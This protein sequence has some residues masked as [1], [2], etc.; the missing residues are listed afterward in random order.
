M[1]PPSV[2]WR[3]NND[4]RLDRRAHRLWRARKSAFESGRRIWRG[5]PGY[6][7]FPNLA[8]PGQG[9][10]VS[11]RFP[12]LGMT[13]FSGEETLSVSTIASLKISNST[14][15]QLPPPRTL[16]TEKIPRC[17]IN[18]SAAQ[19]TPIPFLSDP[20]PRRMS[21]PKLDVA[22]LSST[23]VNVTAG[24]PSEVL[25]HVLA[26]DIALVKDDWLA[27]IRRQESL[28]RVCRRWRELVNGTS[29]YWN[30][31]PV[32]L[33]MKPEFIRDWVERVQGSELTI[34]LFLS[35]ES[36]VYGTEYIFDQPPAKSLSR[37][38]KEV[39]PLLA[40]VFPRAKDLH[41]ETEA[42]GEAVILMREIV[43]YGLSSALTCSVSSRWNSAQDDEEAHPDVEVPLLASLSLDVVNPLSF[44]LS[45][46]ANLVELHISRFWNSPTA[47]NLGVALSMAVRLEVLDLQDVRCE[48]LAGATTTSMLTVKHLSIRYMQD[49]VRRPCD[50]SR[51]RIA[52]HSKRIT[53]QC[54]TTPGSELRRVLCALSS[55]QTID[56]KECSLILLDNFKE[57][58]LNPPFCLPTLRAIRLPRGV[59]VLAI[60][61]VSDMI[62]KGAL[63]LT[64]NP[65][66]GD[67]RWLRTNGRLGAISWQWR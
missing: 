8:N 35:G 12:A 50:T 55:A 41:V 32:H 21:S 16:L 28:R 65:S 43:L 26:F 58:V 61:A 6:R 24:V 59:P 20:K 49:R 52:K 18:V 67:T 4:T 30:V 3:Y 57:D 62:P 15:G 33:F 51:C 44:G 11:G 38:L 53:L 22:P 23:A 60:G 63:L 34:R 40:G 7:S 39:L 5:N 56:L 10:A 66:E 54:D 13:K 36:P 2:D 19:P 27:L 37:F 64:P 48:D 1:W 46:F 17:P 42:T 9:E 29:H 31:L 25:D 14:R 47:V 45:V